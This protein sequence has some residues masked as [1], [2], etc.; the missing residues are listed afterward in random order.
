MRRSRII[1]FLIL[2][3]H[4][5]LGQ[6]SDETENSIK[7][8][9]LEDKVAEKIFFK[10]D[11]YQGLYTL[12]PGNYAFI[13]PDTTFQKVYRGILSEFP[14]TIA[15]DSLLY[16]RKFYRDQARGIYINGNY[17]YE[18]WIVFKEI[19]IGDEAAKI[20]LFTTS[21]VREEKYQNRYVLVTAHLS[22]K[23]NQWR[24]SKHEIKPIEWVE[25]FKKKYYKK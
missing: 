21:A 9:L 11:N 4:V 7:A 15:S 8:L 12:P 17:G 25:L 3:G 20:V 23:N 6:M 19:S 10:Y 14:N 1:F 5:A 24:V 2:I 13:C 22:N 18:L 16:M